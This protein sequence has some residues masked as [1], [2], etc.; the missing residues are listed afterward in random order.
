VQLLQAARQRA[1]ANAQDRACRAVLSK[2]QCK[3][4]DKE[5][6]KMNDMKDPVKKKEAFQKMQKKCLLPPPSHARVPVLL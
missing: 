5:Q 4:L 3:F 1:Q 2:K 6:A